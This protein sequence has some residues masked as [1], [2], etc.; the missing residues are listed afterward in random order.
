[1]FKHLQ[2]W[3]KERGAETIFM[4]AL[5]DERAQKMEKVYC[6]AGFEPLERT[7]MKRNLI[8]GVATSTALALGAGAGIVG[9]G[10]QASAAKSAARTQAAAADRA[11]Q[12]EREMYDIS[13]GDLAPYREMGYTALKDIEA[14]QAIVYQP[15]W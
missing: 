2:S 11:M 8:M 12:Q 4:I 13:R 15:V 9:A 6:R 10:M 3:S 1:M 14:M 7:F 5:E